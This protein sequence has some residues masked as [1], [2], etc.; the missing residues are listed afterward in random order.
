[1]GGRSWRKWR[2]GVVRNPQQE[3][4]IDGGQTEGDL[5][6]STVI[7]D[8]RARERKLGNRK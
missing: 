3:G 8:V 2:T 1:M 7:R 6:K 5:G 4:K